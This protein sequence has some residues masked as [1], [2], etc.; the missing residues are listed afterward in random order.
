MHR[1]W[2]AWLVSALWAT[3]LPLWAAPPDIRL[4]AAEKAQLGIRLTPV[5]PASAITVEATAT[6][7]AAP[8]QDQMVAL[9][10]PG[11]ITAV[12]TGA[13]D[14]VRPGTPVLRWASA[15]VAEVRRQA[16]EADVE[17]AQARAARDRDERLYEADIIPLARLEASRA[18]LTVA[19]AAQAARQAEQRAGRLPAPGPNEDPGQSVLVAPQ[20][21]TVAEV[22]VAVGQ[23]VEAGTAAVRIVGTQ[24][25]QLQLSLSPE[26]AATLKP[27]DEVQVP[28]RQARAVL[29][30]V[31]PA[32][33]A[34]G[35]VPARARVTEAGSL[36]LGERVTATVAARRDTPAA[37]PTAAAQ[38]WRLPSQSLAQIEGQNWV[39]L[40]VAQGLQPVRVKVLGQAGDDVTVEGALSADAQVAVTGL[41]ALRALHPRER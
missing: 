26:K 17:V 37:G 41:A 21:G 22:L 23:R 31:S 1:L 18:R 10:Y 30:G 7:S 25:L 9:P 34:S 16:Q 29:V 36:R 39:Y 11:L 14:P 15:A 12:L 3:A 19:L 13:G 4:S 32:V 38:R 20:A 27:G 6:V 24:A 40:A 8:G 5:Q 33:D 28:A 2:Q 35:Q